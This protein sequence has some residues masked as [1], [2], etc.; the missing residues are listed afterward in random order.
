[1]KSRQTFHVEFRRRIGCESTKMC[2]LGHNSTVSKIVTTKWI[3]VNDLLNVQYSTKKNIRFKTP[4]L[5]SELCD[6]SNV[7]IA[8]KRTITVD[9]TNG[10][11][12]TNHG[13]IIGTEIR[14]KKIPL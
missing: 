12:Q 10:N 8:V 5:R 1:M 9:S 2:P 3:K 14:C 6:Y 11:D 7:H 4:M 13:T